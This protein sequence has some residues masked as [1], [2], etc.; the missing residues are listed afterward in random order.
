[1]NSGRNAY[2]CFKCGSSG[3]PLDL[4]AAVTYVDEGGRVSIATQ[5]VNGN[6]NLRVCNSGSSLTGDE[7]PHVFDRFWRHDKARTD[8]GVH[9]GLGLS[10]TRRIV[11]RLGGTVAAASSVGG[12]F[13][14]TIRLPKNR[15][16]V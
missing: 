6:V 15:E 5:A 8:V 12:E 10:L 13:E 16:A 14:I 9:W 3:N 11:Q 2:P 1:M 7:V 4:W